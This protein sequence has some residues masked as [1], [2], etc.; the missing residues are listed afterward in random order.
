MSKNKYKW[1]QVNH[2]RFHLVQLSLIWNFLSADLPRY[3]C[4]IHG[5][6]WTPSSI[7]HPLSFHYLCFMLHSLSLPPPPLAG[8]KFKLD[9][10]VDSLC[11]PSVAPSPFLSSSSSLSPSL[12]GHE[13]PQTHFSPEPPPPS[14]SSLFHSISPCPTL[15]I[16]LPAL[17]FTTHIHSIVNKAGRLGNKGPRRRRGTL[18]IPASVY[19]VN[20]VS[21]LNWIFKALWCLITLWFFKI[22]FW[23]GDFDGIGIPSIIKSSRY[24]LKKK[25]FSPF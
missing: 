13:C 12:G 25:V 4:V 15:F 20:L 9:T 7:Y 16:F 17:S 14:L 11:H 21:W 24:W 5:A 2:K 23:E 19:L 6:N 8:I 22:F 10:D 1:S 18:R 3:L